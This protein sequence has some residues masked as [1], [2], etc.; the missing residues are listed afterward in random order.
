MLVDH[1]AILILADAFRYNQ[2]K[3]NANL[4]NKKVRK[5]SKVVSSSSPKIQ[6]DSEAAVRLKSQKANL[7]RTGKV[8]DAANVLQQIFS[9]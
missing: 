1:R 2:I 6:D 8:Q 7:K 3:K 4:K 9:R 5:V